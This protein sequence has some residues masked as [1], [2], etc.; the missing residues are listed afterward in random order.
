[1]TN[2]MKCPYCWTHI[3]IDNRN[4]ER[5]N[6]RFDL[7][8]E[9]YT[10]GDS[11]YTNTDILICTNIDCKRIILGFN[12]WYNIHYSNTKTI[13]ESENIQEWKLLPESSARYFNEEI[14]PV[15][16]INDYIEASRIINLSP[17]ASAT[18]FR[19]VIQW[20]IRDF[21]SINKNKLKDAID[22]LELKVEKNV[23]D[24]IETIR[25]CWNIW[26]HMEK[27]IDLII[28][29][30]PHEAEKLK[31]LI[32]FLFEQWYIKKYE[33]N[34]KLEEIKQIWLNK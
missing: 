31:W 17:K 32:E 19:R 26:A 12:F 11:L 5:R 23:W 6:N 28:D 7:W 4:S 34:L 14:I 1:M 2:T 13:S 18:L 22:E 29:I 30:E 24:A 10:W 33:Q 27:D 9:N 16:L 8:V 20:M 15:Q 21:W 25:K 3:I